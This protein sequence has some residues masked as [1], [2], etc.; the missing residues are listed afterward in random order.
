M[1]HG[2]CAEPDA[3]SK[4][5]YDYEQKTKIAIQNMTDARNALK[6]TKSIAFETTTKYVKSDGRKIISAEIGDVKIACTSCNPFL[7]Y[8]GIEEIKVNI[9]I[10]FE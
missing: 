10:K 4:W 9:N 2:K 6:G 1:T 8:F 3:V 5:L 7:E